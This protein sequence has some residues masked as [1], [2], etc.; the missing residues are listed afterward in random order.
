MKA[1]FKKIIL[2][3]FLAIFFCLSS[4][5]QTNSN[6]VK[7]K[8][9]YKKN[10]TYVQPHY[11]TA[12]NSTKNDNFS[13]VGNTNPYTGKPG[14]INRDNNYNTLYYTDYTYSP[15]TYK[16]PYVNPKIKYPDRIYVEDEYGNDT[17]YLKML[18]KRTFGI[19]DLKDELILYLVINHRGDWR[20]FDTEGIYI[21]TIFLTE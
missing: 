6:H 8:G 4:I 5:A 17:T 9:Y 13:T 2:L 12:P 18:D 19:Y 20:I 1:R 11:R 14:W 15:K 3:F 7:V 10:G 21:K 16:E